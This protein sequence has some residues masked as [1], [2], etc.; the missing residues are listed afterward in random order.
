MLKETISAQALQRWPCLDTGA[1]MGFLN[2]MQAQQPGACLPDTT[3]PTSAQPHG[4]HV[5]TETKL[6][7]QCICSKCV[8]HPA[9]YDNTYGLACGNISLRQ[10]AATG[11]AAR[12]MHCSI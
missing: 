4:A 2:W 10:R 8:C 11:H 9:G 12:A 3:A 5:M 7:T 6:Q 1:H